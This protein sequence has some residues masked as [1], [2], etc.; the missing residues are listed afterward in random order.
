MFSFVLWNVVLLLLYFGIFGG[1][2]MLGLFGFALLEWNLYLYVLVCFILL[3]SV[4]VDLLLCF[5]L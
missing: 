3:V 4:Y 1:F 2:C 5:V